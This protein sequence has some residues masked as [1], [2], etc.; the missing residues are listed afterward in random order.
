MN[1]K[2]DT[3]IVFESLVSLPFKHNAQHLLITLS[4]YICKEYRVTID[5]H[6]KIPFQKSHLFLLQI[7]E[8]LINT[9][10][11]ARERP[12][13]QRMA[14]S[15]LNYPRSMHWMRPLFRVA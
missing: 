15:A 7:N 4:L 2:I 14:I 1:F 5:L 9:A 6:D 10:A 3:W 12:A 11:Y 8:W 13:V